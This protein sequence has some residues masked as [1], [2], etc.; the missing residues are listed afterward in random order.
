M[1]EPRKNKFVAQREK[2]E[3]QK[4]II[5]IGTIVIL[6]IVVGLVA[7]GLLEQQLFKP[8]KTII[9]LEEE[10]VRAS[11]FEQR[12]RYQRLN[13]INQAYQLYQYGLQDYIAQIASQ[14]QPEI[15]GQTVLDQMVDELIIR[16]EAEKMGISISE[17]EFEKEVQQ[18]FGYFAAGTPTPAPTLEILPTSTLSPQQ[19]TLVPFTA[20]PTLTLTPTGEVEEE[21]EEDANGEAESEEGEEEV[22]PSPT[23][24]EIVEVEEEDEPVILD[25]TP[26]PLLR[27]TEY[28]FEMYEQN[29]QQALTNLNEQIEMDESTFRNLIRA[30]ILTQKVLEEVTQDVDANP[31][32]VWARHILVDDQETAR[33]LYQQ[34]Q[35][36]ADFAELAREYSNDTSNSENGGSLGWFT[37]DTMVEP[38]SE[39]AF[40]LEVGEISEPVQTDF[41]WHLIQV[42]GKEKRQLSQ[43]QIDQI[44]Q[45]RFE[46]WL[47]DRRAE[48]DPEIAEDWRDYVPSEP[49]LP[50][51]LQ[52]LISQQPQQPQLPAE[53]SDQ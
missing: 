13:L 12:V 6:V 49:A 50:P 32:H 52:Q 30:Y 46:E 7:Y 24:T 34:L 53:E 19:L 14:L 44:K 39:V 37:S 15:V 43:G 35:E 11:E 47:A 21:G 45:Q 23:A 33:D 22:E 3:R 40:A 20:T 28:T 5:L 10:S 41:G 27:P 18:I 1:P 8:R 4:K 16:I 2:E 26:T 17:E 36:G 48:Y 29:Y 31:V 38:F 25:P 42:V 9:K 51:E